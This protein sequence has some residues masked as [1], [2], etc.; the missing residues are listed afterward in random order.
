MTNPAT[1]STD[2]HKAKKQK[3]ISERLSKCWFRPSDKETAMEAI[4][5]LNDLTTLRRVNAALVEALEIGLAL[6]EAYAKD[7]KAD[8]RAFKLATHP[9]TAALRQSKGEA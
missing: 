7:A 6:A 9:I 3:P 8:M 1:G 5:A 2:G 4:A